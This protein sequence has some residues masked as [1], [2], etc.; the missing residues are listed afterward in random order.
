MGKIRPTYIK[1]VALELVKK[2]PKAFNDD[3]EHNKLLVEKLTDVYS[4]AMRNRIAGYVTRYWQ[5]LEH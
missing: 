1:R 3:F 5:Q 4:P 2:Y